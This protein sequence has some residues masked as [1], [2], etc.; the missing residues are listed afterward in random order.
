MPRR[1]VKSRRIKSRNK[2]PFKLFFIFVFVAVGLLSFAQFN[3]KGKPSVLGVATSAYISKNIAWN[4]VPGAVGYNI[5][6]KTDKE[7]RYTNAVRNLPASYRN[8]TI[9]YLLKSKKYQYEVKAYEFSG[10]EFWSTGPR[11]IQASR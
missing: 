5:Y 3:S 9:N 11:W 2:H 6:F 7:G 10:K 4:S 8:Y 1:K